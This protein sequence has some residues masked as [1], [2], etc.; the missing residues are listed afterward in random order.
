MPRLKYTCQLSIDIEEEECPIPL[1]GDFSNELRD[2]IEDMIHE[3][4]GIYLMKAHIV[5][6]GTANG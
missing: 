6:R 5:K 1:D 4:D 2:I 3:C